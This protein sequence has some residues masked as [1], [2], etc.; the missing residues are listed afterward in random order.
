MP[1]KKTHY[2]VRKG[3]KPG[4]YTSWFGPGGAKEQVKDFPRAEFKGFYSRA[5]AEAWLNTGGAILRY[6]DKLVDKLVA[7]DNTVLPELTKLGRQLNNPT[8]KA[9]WED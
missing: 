7:G 5:D 3:R 1:K 2:A 9:P 8:E 6:Y 4:I